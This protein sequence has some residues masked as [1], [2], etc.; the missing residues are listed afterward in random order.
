MK[1]QSDDLAPL[2]LEMSLAFHTHVVCKLK[3][4][5]FLALAVALANIF[6]VPCP[7]TPWRDIPTPISQRLRVSV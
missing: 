6:F 7:Q 3:F 1:T 5:G 4:S 2:H